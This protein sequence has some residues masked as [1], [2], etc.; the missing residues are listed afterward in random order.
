ME[1]LKELETSCL[2][3]HLLKPPSLLLHVWVFLLKQGLP[4]PWFCPVSSVSVLVWGS[5]V[6]NGCLVMWQSPLLPHPRAEQS[7]GAGEEI[8]ANPDLQVARREHCEYMLEHALLR[9]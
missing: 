6:L 1:E 3:L 5:A 9:L 8:S 7:G 4:L 2:W